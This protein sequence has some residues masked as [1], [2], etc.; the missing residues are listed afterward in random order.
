MTDGR[1]EREHRHPAARV[2]AS[3]LPSFLGLAPLGDGSDGFMWLAVSYYP[4]HR[5][6]NHSLGVVVF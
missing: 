1:G 6:N 5:G 4:I 2:T 3:L